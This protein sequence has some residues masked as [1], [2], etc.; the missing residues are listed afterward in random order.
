MQKEL[1]LT[2]YMLTNVINVSQKLKEM[3]RCERKK[4]KD[5]STDCLGIVQ[6]S[7]FHDGF[8]ALLFTKE[9]CKVSSG[10]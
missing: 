7:S 5:K 3:D 9:S 6:H 10:K 1:N 2:N 4:R 8:E